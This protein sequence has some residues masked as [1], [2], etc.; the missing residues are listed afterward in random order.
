MGNFEEGTKMVKEIVKSL[1][2]TYYKQDEEN[3]SYARAN[4]HLVEKAR[5]EAKE[6]RRRGK[7]RSNPREGE[8]EKDEQGS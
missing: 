6:K 4:I 5:I 2:Q 8:G 3:I 7:Q 1:G